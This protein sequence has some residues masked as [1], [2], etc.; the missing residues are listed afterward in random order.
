MLVPLALVED[1]EAVTD[2]TY[3]DEIAHLWTGEELPAGCVAAGCG[4]EAAD[5]EFIC[6]HGCLLSL[7]RSMERLMPTAQ[8]AQRP[9]GNV[10]CSGTRSGVPTSIWIWAWGR[11]GI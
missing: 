5:S 1:E 2:T 3:F 11:S 9:G 10:M 4:V 8:G 7:C 6:V